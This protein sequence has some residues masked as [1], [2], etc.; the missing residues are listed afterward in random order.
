MSALS[1]RDFEFEARQL[2][3]AMA[4]RGCRSL[5]EIGRELVWPW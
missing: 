1:L 3:G 5:A 2:D 4:L